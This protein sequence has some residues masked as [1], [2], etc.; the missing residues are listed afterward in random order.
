MGRRLGDLAVLILAL[1]LYVM[2]LAPAIRVAV[3]SDAALAPQD[4][5]ILVYGMVYGMMAPIGYFL[6]EVWW[7]RALNLVGGVVMATAISAASFLFE[8]HRPFA[9]LGVLLLLFA[10]ALAVGFVEGASRRRRRAMIALAET[11]AVAV[12]SDVVRAARGSA[13][14]GSVSA[15]A[16]M[17]AERLAL[18]SVWMAAHEAEA[19]GDVRQGIDMSLARLQADLSAN[20][21]IETAPLAARLVGDVRVRMQETSWKGTLRQR[22]GSKVLSFRS[23]LPQSY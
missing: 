14:S 12:I 11:D 10:A 6:S 7:R 8:S 9:A 15:Q 21:V 1:T 13:S 4:A 19:T 5:A 17:L 22:S 23:S 3:V 2:S 16:A 20:P 18:A